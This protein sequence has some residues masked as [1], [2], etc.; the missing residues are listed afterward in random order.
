[1]KISVDVTLDQVCKTVSK[2][3]FEKDSP[4][5]ASLLNQTFYLVEATSLEICH[6]WEHYKGKGFP[7][8]CTTSFMTQIGQLAEFEVWITLSYYEIKGKVIC[9]YEMT[10]NYA[11][12][13]ICESFFKNVVP[14]CPTTNAD[15]FHNVM[16]AIES[17]K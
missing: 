8:S 3:D 12:G 14:R 15:N 2:E 6:L 5:D 13:A 10:G 7:S 9:F 11:F 4:E 1:M 17:G 16:L